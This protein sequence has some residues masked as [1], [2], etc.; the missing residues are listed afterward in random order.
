MALDSARF[1]VGDDERNA[2]LVFRI[3]QSKAIERIDLS[4][5]LDTKSDKESDIEGAARIGQRIYW[6]TS[7]GRNS[8]GEE[9][10]RRQRF[11]ATDLVRSGSLSLQPVDSAYT[12]LLADLLRAPSLAD[13][14]LERAAKL[15]PEVPGGL[16]IEGLAATPNG[17]LLLGFRSPLRGNRAL[18]AV[19]RNPSALLKGNPAQFG[20]PIELDL[21]GRGI[22]SIE[23]VGAR[24]VIIAGPTA[25]SGSFALFEWTGRSM[26][27]PSVVAGSNFG[28]EHPEALFDFAT[29]GQR[30]SLSDDGGRMIGGVRCKD[31]PAGEQAFRARRLR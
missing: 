16:N 17:A 19:L 26:D 3:G 24:Y 8:R 21:G 15:A 27:R 23:R 28:D 13:F 9:Q 6:I 25:D 22:R 1:V 7:H 20:A 4:R 5:Y 11:F 31:L 14:N 18:L 10:Q 30:Y 29:T 2:L 12:N